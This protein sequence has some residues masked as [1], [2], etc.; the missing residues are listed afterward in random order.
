MIPVL[1]TAFELY[2]RDDLLSDLIG[3]LSPPGRGGPDGYRRDLPTA[4]AQLFFVV[5]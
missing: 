5:E 3:S 1:R 4:G 2:K